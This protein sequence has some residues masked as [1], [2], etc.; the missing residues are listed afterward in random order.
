[1]L[2]K[3]TNLKYFPDI[4]KWNATKAIN[5]LYNNHLYLIIILK[6]VII[7]N[8]RHNHFYE[9]VSIL[10]ISNFQISI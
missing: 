10:K 5:I 2:Y 7:L 8:N 3:I 9:C 4:E 1:M 6:F